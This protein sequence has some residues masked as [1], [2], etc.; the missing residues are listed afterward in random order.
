MLHSILYE[1][2][3]MMDRIIDSCVTAMLDYKV[4]DK[5]QQAVMVYGLDLLF[6]SIVS[7]V[8]LVLLGLFLNR[9]M[10][11]LWLLMIFIPLQSFGGGYHCQTHFRCWL[12][13]LVGYLLTMFVVVK[14]PLIL[15][16]S[17]AVLGAYSFLRLAPIE[18]PKAAF[19][20]KFRRKMRQ[21]V[22]CFYIA[23]LIL[24]AVM[25]V[26]KIEWNKIILI[27]IILSATSI[28]SAEIKAKLN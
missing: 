20:L 22:I 3:I 9:G 8:S 14:V 26:F 1:V 24:A 11:T 13:M 19:G 21:S 23:A 27:A 17:G 5:R 10:Q 18:N 6:S 16:W 4:I 2:V 28:L 12:L 7:L 15:L 25:T